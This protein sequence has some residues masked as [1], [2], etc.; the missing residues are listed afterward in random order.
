MIIKVTI[1]YGSLMKNSYNPKILIEIALDCSE[2]TIS[3][4]GLSNTLLFEI[5]FLEVP[6]EIVKVIIMVK[7][8]TL[9]MKGFA[10]VCS[11]IWNLL[12]QFLEEHQYELL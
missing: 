7:K 8:I 4:L 9:N 12:M 11:L 6:Q 10:A 1:K 5:S 3:F 2:G